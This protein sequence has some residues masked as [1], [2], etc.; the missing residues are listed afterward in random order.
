MLPASRLA[1]R[2]A[3]EV[4]MVVLNA[5]A[6]MIATK[7]FNIV[8]IFFSSFTGGLMLSINIVAGRKK[9]FPEKSKE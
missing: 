6:R 7:S 5:T 1:M 2:A 3:C 8:F 9:L 4:I